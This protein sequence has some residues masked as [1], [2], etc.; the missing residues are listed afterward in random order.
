VVFELISLSSSKVN[1]VAAVTLTGDS[2]DSAVITVDMLDGKIML[3]VGITLS[4][5]KPVMGAADHKMKLC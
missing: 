3:K 1:I 4:F 2:V 5:I